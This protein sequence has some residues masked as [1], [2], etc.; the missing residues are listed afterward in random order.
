MDDEDDEMFEHRGRRQ[1][2]SLR[3][4]DK[5]TILNRYKLMQVQLQDRNGNFFTVRRKVK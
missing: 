4:S 5:E 3:S 1:I 2:R